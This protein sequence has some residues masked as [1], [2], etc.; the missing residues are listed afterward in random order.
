MSKTLTELFVD[1]F[2][3]CKLKPT[4]TVA[5]ISELGQKQDYVEAAVQAARAVGA[6]AVALTATEL[7]HAALPPVQP[8]S[9]GVVALLAGA[10]ECDMVVDVTVGGLIH[11]DVRTRI[12]GRGKRMLFVAEPPEVLERLMGSDDLRQ[13]VQ[14]AG[15]KL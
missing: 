14:Y 12:T 2:R 6:G 7:S 4:E 8:A 5:V 1:Q 15:S 3:L 11:S 10:A 9:R 13:R